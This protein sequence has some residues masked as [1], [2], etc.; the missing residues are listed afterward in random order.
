MSVK[1]P[2]WCLVTFAVSR[3][4][5][6]KTMR[7]SEIFLL[8]LI[9][10]PASPEVRCLA[11]RNFHCCCGVKECIFLRKLSADDHFLIPTTYR[12]E[13]SLHSLRDDGEKSLTWEFR[14]LCTMLVYLR[15]R[16]PSQQ[17]AIN[18]ALLSS[19][20]RGFRQVIDSSSGRLL[21]LRTQKIMR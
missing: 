4:F 15:S 21:E 12:S 19:L 5:S 16:P 11:D 9:A 18:P 2:G 6:M 8:R 13:R 3:K 10:A 7:S 14:C 20:G 17:N 1:P